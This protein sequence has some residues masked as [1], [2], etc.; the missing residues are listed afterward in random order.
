[1]HRFGPRCLGSTTRSSSGAGHADGSDDAAEIHYTLN[2][3]AQITIALTDPTSGKRFVF[4]NAEAR[5]AGNY[6]VLFSGIV[7]GY[8]L[9]GE[10]PGGDIETRLA[11]LQ[12]MPNDETNRAAALRFLEERDALGWSD[13]ATGF[14]TV[15]AAAKQTTQVVYVGDGIPTLGDA[16]PSAFAADVAKFHA[17]RGTVHAVVPGNT[18]EPIVLRALS[19]LGG[20]TIR[21]IGGGTDPMQTATALLTEI[22]TPVVHDLVL[23]IDG[24]AAAAVY[25]EVL[26]NLPA[27]REQVIV[28]RLIA[29]S[30]CSA[31]AFA[32]AASQS[33]RI[34]PEATLSPPRWA[35]GPVPLVNSGFE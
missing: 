20:G 32:S 1:V 18:S 12:P 21:S 34:G 14:K 15:L 19:R 11:F 8:T 23:S 17:G 2:R 30:L 7:D 16:D 25:P 4:R 29:S 35:P 9:P 33:S 24:I 28:G 22:A 27:G 31:C 26:P 10:N 5:P 6:T 3:N 13:L